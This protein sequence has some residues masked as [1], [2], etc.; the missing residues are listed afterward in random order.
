VRRNV[1]VLAALGATGIALLFSTAASAKPG[2]KLTVTPP[3]V[4]TNTGATFKWKPAKGTVRLLCRLRW[5]PLPSGAQGARAPKH[6]ARTFS[7]C[8]SPTTWLG[9]VPGRYTFALVA[10]GREKRKRAAT[11]HWRIL[12]PGSPV[13]PPP[14]PP[15]HSPPPPPP[16][17][18]PPP[19]PPP[20]GPPP[21]PPAGP[22][23]PP[24]PAPPPPP[25]PGTSCAA[26]PYKYLKPVEPAINA[27][28][29][30]FVNLVNQARQ[31]LGLQPLAIN[32]KLSLAA[33]S[34]S[35]W[36][37]SF[38]GRTGLEHTGCNGSTPWQRIAEAG[39]SGNYLGE[40]TLVNSAGANAQTAFNMFK[41]SPGHW[42]LLT[43]PNFTQIGIGKSSWH[44]TGDLGG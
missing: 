32:S 38:Y 44:W 24:P 21:P 29:Q 15:G 18:H 14:P 40:V 34:H 25:P 37:D 17:G 22:P 12:P 13:P 20:P 42:A 23:P 9:L 11:F 43:S 31:S 10:I 4:T 16:P 8:T 30:Q 41:G 39:Y 28:E 7:R 35:Y 2:A 26:S 5:Q 6:L 36:Q 3:A 19:P 33:D 27:D 1:L